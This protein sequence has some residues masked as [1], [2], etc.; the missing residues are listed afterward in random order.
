MTEKNRIALSKANKG[1]PQTEEHKKNLRI[2]KMKLIIEKKGKLTT[3][4]GATEFFNKINQRGYNFI[5]D[6]WLSNLG[7]RVDGYDKE[8]HTIIE[9]DTLYHNSNRQ[10]KRDLIRQNKQTYQIK[11]NQ[12]L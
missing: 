9:Y 8:K 1:R 3:D 2:A 12:A 4:R 5:Q 11:V 7:Y 10:Q 6:Y